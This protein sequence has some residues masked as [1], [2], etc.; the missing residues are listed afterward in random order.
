MTQ[1]PP[2]NEKEEVGPQ[3]KEEQQYLSKAGWRALF[4]FTTRQ[5]VPILTC[6]LIGAFISA[7]AIPVF[8]I[9]YGLIFRNYT[10]YG[11]GKIE[12]SE[13][14]DRVTRFCLI[15]T[16]V[17]SLSWIANS[18][19]FFF[20]LTFGELQARSARNKIFDALIRKDMAWYDTRETGI[21]AFLPAIQM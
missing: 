20:F 14:R 19:Y 5:H 8:A 15:L 11:A 4:G 2:S 13:L 9:I 18:F 7:A 10:D 21:A 6:G 3:A 12:S 16:G 1:P 17:A